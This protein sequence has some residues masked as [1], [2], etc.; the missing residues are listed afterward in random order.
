MKSEHQRINAS[1]LW[2]WRKL[3]RVAW[4][5]RKSNQSILKEINPEHSLD[6]LMVK[7]KFNPLAMWCEELTHWERPWCWERLRARGEGDKRGWD[8]WMASLSQWTWV[9]DGEG[10][11]SLVCCSPW[12]HKES[13]MTKWWT[14]TTSFSVIHSSDMKSGTSSVSGMNKA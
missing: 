8:G 10:Q 6:W 12:G 4:I 2:C 3:L 14:T 13:E 5:G 7:L 9:W 1:K 11:G